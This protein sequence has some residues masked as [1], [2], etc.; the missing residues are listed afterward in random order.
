M[1]TTKSLPALLA[2]VMGELNK[3]LAKDQFNKQQKYAFVGES[4]ISNAVR[5]LLAE[6][7]IWLWSS[8]V[9]REMVPLYTSSS[10]AQMWLTRVTMQYRFI[11]G[12]QTTE[13][14]TYSGQGA[15]I[16][17]KGLPKAQS[18]ALKY[19]LL[20][21]FMLSTGKDDAESDENVDKQAAAAG[22]KKG[23]KVKGKAS[24]TA[25]RGGKT[26][27]ITPTQ[28]KAITKLV[29]DKGLTAPGF[30]AVVAMT[31]EGLDANAADANAVMM[32][33]TS[34]QAG[35]VI[36]SLSDLTES[37][38]DGGESGGETVDEEAMSIV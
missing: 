26:D 23:A 13:I 14:Q 37:E 34:K 35:E 2:E 20:K 28:V 24:T 25:K 5:P 7:G 16:G 12:E 19:F 27:G 36:Q 32:D 33:L 11:L 18:M 29:K 17:D 8:E 4:A 6:R 22:A 38:E 9:E 31:V 21:T 1:P 3:P 10:G 15:D 30:L